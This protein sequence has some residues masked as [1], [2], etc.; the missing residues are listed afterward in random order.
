MTETGRGA[1]LCGA[2]RFSTFGKLRAVSACHCSQCRKQSGHFWAATD[3]LENEL[4]LHDAD[5]LSWYVST[6]GYRRG[7]CKTCGSL[8]LWKCE[9]SDKIS[10]SA[11][12]F[13]SPTALKLETHIYC[14]DKGDY[15][16]ISD[17]VPQ[18][19]QGCK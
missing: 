8:L 12:S 7:F 11:G 9:A 19:E 1:C 3:V 10:V 6:P 5:N 17:G 18:F 16:E 14:A 13:E 15:Y 2:V 4:E